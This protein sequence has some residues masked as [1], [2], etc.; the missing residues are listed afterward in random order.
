M[1]YGEQRSP[2]EERESTAG[3]GVAHLESQ[4]SVRLEAEA[5]GLYA[6]SQLGSLGRLYLKN[7]IIK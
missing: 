7:K 3:N 5:G 4:N 6:P 1:D 2:F